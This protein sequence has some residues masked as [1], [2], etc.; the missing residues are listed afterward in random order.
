MDYKLF[1]EKTYEYL[2]DV[3][4]KH[5]LDKVKLESYFNPQDNLF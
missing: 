5:N 2:C 4:E 3:A 1:Y